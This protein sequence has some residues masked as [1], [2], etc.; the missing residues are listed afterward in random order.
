MEKRNR[1]LIVDDTDKNYARYTYQK[2]GLDI[3]FLTIG[4]KKEAAQIPGELLFCLP[5]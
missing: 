4:N 2:N 5:A 1:I 3:R